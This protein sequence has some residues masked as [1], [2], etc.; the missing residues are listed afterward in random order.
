MLFRTLLLINTLFSLCWLL[1]SS[2][3]LLEVLQNFGFIYFFTGL[4]SLLLIFILNKKITGF[5]LVVSL[6]NITNVFYYGLI[7]K[8]FFWQIASIENAQ[9][10]CSLE[11]F[12]FKLLYAN[13][14]ADGGDLK[15]LSEMINRDKPDVVALLEV[16]EDRLNKLKLET[17]YTYNKKLF[18]ENHYDVSLFSKFPITDAK[19]ESVGED[20]RPHIIKKIDFPNGAKINL[21]LLHAMPPISND[22][23]VHNK[24]LIRRLITMAKYTKGN[25]LLLGDFN[26]T[27]FSSNINMITDWAEFKHAA[28]GLGYYNSW[29]AFYP[30][31]TFMIDHIFTKGCIRASNFQKLEAFNSDH[32]PLKAE[33]ILN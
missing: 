4:I 3:W 27:P 32:Y 26:A 33:F 13:V 17:D 24:I 28:Y 12:K 16:N 10:K 23:I 14:F 5:I 31:S 9:S 30:I 21:I 2:H 25:Y 22:A 7:I 8:P 19:I 29:N 6:L 1:P 20:L 11:D 15:K 18:Y